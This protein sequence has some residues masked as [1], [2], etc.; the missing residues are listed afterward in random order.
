MISS[1][2]PSSSSSS[3]P[4]GWRTSSFSSS[5]RARWRWR[6]CGKSFLEPLSASSRDCE[7]CVDDLCGDGILWF[8]RVFLSLRERELEKPA[9]FVCWSRAGEG[10]LVRAREE[11][12]GVMVGRPAAVDESGRSSGL[13]DRPGSHEHDGRRIQG[14]DEQ[15][16]PEG[17]LSHAVERGG[18]EKAASRAQEE[19]ETGNWE[20]GK[21]GTGAEKTAS[22]GQT[23]HSL[24]ML[25]DGGAGSREGGE[26]AG[27]GTGWRFAWLCARPAGGHW[28]VRLPRSHAANDAAGEP[29]L[30]LSGIILTRSFALCVS[31]ASST[32][33]RPACARRPWATPPVASPP[34]VRPAAAPRVACCYVSLDR[35]G[36][37][38]EQ[39][40][41]R[42]TRIMSSRWPACHVIR[43]GDMWFLCA[44][45]K[46]IYRVPIPRSASCTVA[47]W[48]SSHGVL[49]WQKKGDVNGIAPEG[50]ARHLSCGDWPS[51]AVVR[52]SGPPCWRPPRVDI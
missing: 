50:D 49:A 3:S 21:Q 43:L 30:V 36:V 18:I 26:R 8:E 31:P 41:R 20:T 34:V 51:G 11:R 25:R 14:E 13:A 38:V 9:E 27:D 10:W 45:D 19:L 35:T 52:S 15:K 6:V 37:S 5:S 48:C 16:L 7:R 33:S 29:A 24:E 39:R 28:L 4:A 22:R 42:K 17:E 47:L 1:S 12:R 40:E 46:D 44:G 23:L 32:V 2:S